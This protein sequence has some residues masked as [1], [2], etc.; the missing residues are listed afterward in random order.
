[1]DGAHVGPGHALAHHVRG[2]GQPP[3]RRRGVRQRRLVPVQELRRLEVLCNE[4][5]KR[6]ILPVQKVLLGLVGKESSTLQG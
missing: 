4:T 1:M 6:F 2:V 3:H 5:G